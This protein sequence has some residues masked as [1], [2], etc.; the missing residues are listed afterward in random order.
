MLNIIRADIY[1]I[2]K[3]TG[4][5]FLM[6]LMWVI[7]LSITFLGGSWQIDARDASQILVDESMNISAF[8]RQIANN[9]I[10]FYLMIIPVFVIINTDLSKNT[11][12]NTIASVTNKKTYY[13]SKCI[14]AEFVSAAAL[15]IFNFVFWLFASLAKGM[16][17]TMPLGDILMITLRQI[18]IFI[19]AVSV[20]VFFAFLLRKSA[21]FVTLSLI[22]QRSYNLFLALLSYILNKTGVYNFIDKFFVKYEMENAI[23]I[24]TLQPT[25]DYTLKCTLIYLSLAVVLTFL[26]YVFFRK[27]EIV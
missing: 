2:F 4:I 8:Q 15:I 20:M 18:P 23:N 11:V 9:N 10:L 25:A 1:R 12:K 24:V 21:L 14:G 16:D 5:Y 7:M 3:S 27:K 22:M 6:F 17:F 19:G 13:F 26:G